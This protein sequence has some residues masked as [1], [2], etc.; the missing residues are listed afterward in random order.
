MKRI[1]KRKKK[2]GTRRDEEKCMKI[3]ERIDTHEEK[4]ENKVRRLLQRGE[5]KVTKEKRRRKGPRNER[6][7]TNDE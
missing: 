6:E 7:G 5:N 3:L 2:K 1:K 4:A